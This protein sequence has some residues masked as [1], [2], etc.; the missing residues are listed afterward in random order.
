MKR[1]VLLFAVV[2][3]A[4]ESPAPA[5]VAS[6]PAVPK[7]AAPLV[8]T[9]AYRVDAS[10]A[11]PCKVGASCEAR[12][13]LTALAPYKVNAEYPTKFVADGG[14]PVEGEGTFVVEAKQRGTLTVR[15]TPTAAGPA[16]VT[17][18]FKLSVCTEDNCEIEAPKITLEVPVS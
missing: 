7:G 14:L 13:I 4:K 11:A 8:E 6:A 16:R 17:G 12:A 18:T 10:V 3:C 9:A 15:F 2:A 1:A 5:P